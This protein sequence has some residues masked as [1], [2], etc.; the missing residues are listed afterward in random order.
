LAIKSIER[1]DIDVV[2]NGNITR[3]RWAPKM[4]KFNRLSGFSMPPGGTW[5]NGKFT[6][7]LHCEQTGEGDSQAY[8][9]G[10]IEIRSRSIVKRIKVAGVCGC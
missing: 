9:K 2:I 4:G 8:L 3:L 7:E 1:P 5:S 6:L 10:I